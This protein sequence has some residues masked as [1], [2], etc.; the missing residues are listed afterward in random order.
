M[1]VLWKKTE[2]YNGES[3]HEVIVIATGGIRE[4][5]ESLLQRAGFPI[6]GA[7]PSHQIFSPPLE[8]LSSPYC[9]PKWDTKWINSQGDVFCLWRVFFLRICNSKTFNP[10][11]STEFLGECH[12][13][14]EQNLMENPG[15]S[16]KEPWLGFRKQNTLLFGFLMY[17]RQV[18]GLRWH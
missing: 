2:F 1:S 7:L 9:C 17:L 18:N 11:P 8:S 5:A 15:R 13:P 10:L 4:G 6:M 3:D 12:Q 14:T 16:K